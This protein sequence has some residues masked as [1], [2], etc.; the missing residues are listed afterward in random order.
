MADQTNINNQKIEYTEGVCN[1]GAAI[2]MNGE[3]MTISE[4]IKRL[5]TL[6][7]YTKSMS[8][9]LAEIGNI[10]NVDEGDVPALIHWQSKQKTHELTQNHYYVDANT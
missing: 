1:D 5:N 6:Q 3:M 7:Q 2:L 8:E 10:A 4:V 9:V